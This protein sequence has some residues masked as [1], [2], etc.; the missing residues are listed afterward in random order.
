MT[1]KVGEAKNMTQF[2]AV[3]VINEKNRFYE[4]AQECQ[5]RRSCFTSAEGAERTESANQLEDMIKADKMAKGIDFKVVPASDFLVEVWY[6]MSPE[7]LTEALVKGEKVALAHKCLESKSNNS[8]AP[9]KSEDEESNDDDM[10]QGY[11]TE[12]E[13]TAAALAGL[14]A[15]Q[16]KIAALIAK[17]S[18][19]EV[20]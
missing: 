1:E 17:V 9:V 20:A 2:I 14:V 11:A 6:A 16:T 13:A 8:L 10:I 19:K 5:R 4:A 15:L 3:T 7:N 12:A 18:V